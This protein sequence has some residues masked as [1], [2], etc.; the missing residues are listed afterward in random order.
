MT[1][2]PAFPCP[3]ST[4]DDGVIL[5]HPEPGMSLRD[6]FA[7]KA[8]AGAITDPK[9]RMGNTD[10]WMPTMAMYSY[11]IADAMLAAREAK[12]DV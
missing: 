2:E 6:Y 4:R 7:A 1:Y 5:Q 9:L 10:N 11:K 3:V 8:M 12:P